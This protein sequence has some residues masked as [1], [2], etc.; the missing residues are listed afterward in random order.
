[1]NGDEGLRADRW[2]HHVRIFKTRSLAGKACNNGQ[3]LLRGQKVKASRLLRVDD[4]LEVQRGELRLRVRVIGFP[5]NRVGAKLVP[6]YMENQTP[7]EWI[8]K[9]AERSREKRLQQPNPHEL[10]FKPNK[11]QMRQL[12]EFWDDE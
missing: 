12:R 2:L 9:A 4:L 7:E 8:R 1:M 3:V 10:T 5:A 11:Q 6:D